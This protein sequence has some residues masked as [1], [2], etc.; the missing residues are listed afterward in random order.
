[1]SAS[2]RPDR[3]I[4]V[5][6]A[7]VVGSLVALCVGTSFAESLFPVI[8]AEGT[9]A[10]R[11]GFAALVL[12]LVWRPWRRP[13]ARRDA[14]WICIYGATLGLTNLLFYLSLRTMPLGVALALEITGPLGLAVLSS[15]R[16]VDFTWIALAAAGLALLLLIG[17]PAARPDRAGATYALGAGVMWALYIVFGQ[18]AANA[19]GGQA[20]SIGLLC[21]ALVTLPFGVVQA[22]TG[23]LAP[24]VL[25]AGLAVGI[26]S[27]ALPYSLEM[28]ALKRLPRR[29]FGIL[30]SL[31][32]AVGA[33]A[34]VLFLAERLTAGQWAGIV[35]IMAAAVGCTATARRAVPTPSVEVTAAAA[36]SRE[37][38]AG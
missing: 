34:G 2:H 7:C 36:G 24:A 3:S 9:V 1:M 5:P 19:H 30:L 12:L 33:L 29:T 23:L 8:G 11:T 17:G 28:V 26:V 25:L 16:L 14:V 10:L 6:V 13:L 37:E 38:A 15:R 22:G 27:S 31:E 32:P 20:T 18:K 35:C 4:L 21:A